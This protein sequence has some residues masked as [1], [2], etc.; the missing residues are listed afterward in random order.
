MN[1]G[2]HVIKDL[3]TR[4]NKPSEYKKSLRDRIT[5]GRKVKSYH[6]TP[7]I[8]F[9]NTST[10]MSPKRVEASP[11]DREQLLAEMEKKKEFMGKIKDLI[12]NTNFAVGFTDAS[13]ERKEGA[14]VDHQDYE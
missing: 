12:H 6:T 11:Q 5:E 2:D 8:S 10:S 4:V 7:K 9:G 14:T 13:F 1:E 3:N